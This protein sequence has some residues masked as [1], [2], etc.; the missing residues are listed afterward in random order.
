VAS[1]RAPR[2]DHRGDPDELDEFRD[3][4][5]QLIPFEFGVVRLVG[6]ELGAV[7]IVGFQYGSV[8]NGRAPPRL[9]VIRRG[10][11]GLTT[12]GCRTRQADLR[13]HARRCRVR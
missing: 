9:A 8:R 12:F 1:T 3:D 11:G 10:V 5:V 2:A 13:R 6:F 4:A 7:R